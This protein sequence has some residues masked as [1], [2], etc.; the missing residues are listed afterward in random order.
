MKKIDEVIDA[1]RANPIRYAAWML[2]LVVLMAIGFT[3]GDGL[4][5]EFYLFTH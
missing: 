1:V 3:I 2:V 4:G 5:I